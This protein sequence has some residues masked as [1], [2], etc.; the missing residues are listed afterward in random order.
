MDTLI[1]WCQV[2]LRYRRVFSFRRLKLLFL[3]GQLLISGLMF[4]LYNNIYG[5]LIGKIY[6]N[7]VLGL[8]NR[9]NEFSNMIVNNINGPIQSVLLPELLEMQEDKFKLKLMG[10]RSIK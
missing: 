10:R 5:L 6:N 1:L 7:S 9:C 8:Y 4:V 2:K 3:A